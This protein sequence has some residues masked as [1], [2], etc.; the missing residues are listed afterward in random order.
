MSRETEITKKMLSKL[1]EDRDRKIEEAAKP[2]E[3]AAPVEH[4][5]FLTR[6]KILMHE[7]VEKK[8]LNEEEY[9]TI[10]KNTPQFGDIRVSQEEQ[11]RQTIG[12]NITLDSDALKFYPAL[13]G[14]PNNQDL[15][16]TG[17]I[18]SLGLSF[19]FRYQDSSSDG[20]FIWCDSLQLTKENTRTV[21]KIRDAFENWRQS[22]TDDA[23]L[24]Q[25]LKTAATRS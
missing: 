24:M 25:K 7:A 14:D 13:D 8:N 3:S 23:S 17:K 2:F 15:T 11:L 12:E 20:C 21:G 6:S 10:D 9:L 5:N 22:I 18:G 16:L 4:D 19:Q 1:R